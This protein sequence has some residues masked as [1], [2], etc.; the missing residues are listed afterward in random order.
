M[1]TKKKCDM[2]KQ[3]VWFLNSTPLQKKLSRDA[4]FVCPDMES[5]YRN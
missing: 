3:G 5:A 2:S 1:K 4:I